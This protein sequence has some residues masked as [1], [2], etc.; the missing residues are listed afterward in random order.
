MINRKYDRYVVLTLGIYFGWLLTFPFYG[1]VLHQSIEFYQTNDYPLASIFTF[2]HAITLILGGLIL[3]NVSRWRQI[4][5]TGLIASLVT[6]I[7]LIFAPPTI[8]ALGMAILGASAS[9]YLLGWSCI[10]SFGIPSMGH[11]KKVALMIIIANIIYIA[12]NSLAPFMHPSLLIALALIPLVAV[13]IFQLLNPIT[14]KSE[15]ISLSKGEPAHLPISLVI[16][17]CVFVLGLYLNGGLMY[18]IMLPLLTEGLPSYVKF[19]PYIGVLLIM[20]Y[21]GERLQH[22]FSVYI[23]LSLMGLAFVAFALF[24]KTLLGLMVTSSLIEASFAFIDLFVWTSLGTLVLIYGAPYRFFG[25]VIGS[26]ALSIIIGD[27]ASSR[28]LLVEE[29]YRLFT[30]IFAAAAIF[31]TFLI[32]PWLNERMNRDFSQQFTD[33]KED[34]DDNNADDNNPLNTLLTQLLPE[35]QL[36]PR[37][38][39]VVSLIL[40]GMKNKEIAAELFISENTLKTHLKNIYNKFGITQKIDLFSMALGTKKSSHM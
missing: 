32:A 37:E 20:Y 31:F 27:L 13:L 23:G 15:N 14:L 12:F 30:A 10:Y 35:Q 25:L 21:F 1:P 39:E 22:F 36:T 26:M 2:S 28:I 38:V 6:S 24:D 8:W 11:L 16:F 18:T 29:N 5:L 40:Q 33:Q 34:E 3:N 17:F 19:V 7:V 4:M 9:L